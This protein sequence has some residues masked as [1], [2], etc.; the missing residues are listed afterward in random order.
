[1]KYTKNPKLA[2]DF[3]KWFHSKEQFGRW[4]QVAEGFS[5]GSTKFW[6]QH[7][8]WES[9]DP[10]MKGFRTAP[11]NSRVI[12]FAGP[13]SAKATEVYSKYIVVDMFAKGVQGKP[14]DAVKWAADELKKIY[15]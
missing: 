10:P 3:L 4:F 8:L 7:P 14:E 6:E 13:P 15:G 5:V 9:I 2:K 11:D 1:M 12:G